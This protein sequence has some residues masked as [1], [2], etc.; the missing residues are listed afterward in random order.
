MNATTEPRAALSP[1]V[2]LSD[3]RSHLASSKHARIVI[4]TAYRATV[5]AP[6]HADMFRVNSRNEL[7]VARGR[8]WD[9]LTL[10]SLLL[11]GIRFAHV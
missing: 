8:S 3:I 2:L 5:Y 11:V 9:T 7:Q 6:K 1:D 10:G 4:G